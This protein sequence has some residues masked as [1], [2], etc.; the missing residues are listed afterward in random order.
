MAQGQN[1]RRRLIRIAAGFVLALV[2]TATAVTIWALEMPATQPYCKIGPPFA[3]PLSPTQAVFTAKALYVGRIDRTYAED[4]GHRKGL[5]AVARVKRRLWGLPWWSSQIVLLSNG[6]FEKGDEY[7][8]DGSRSSF[9]SSLMPIVDVG[10]CSRTARLEHAEIDLRVLHDGVPA[11]GARVIG[12]VIRQ[13][14][15]GAPEFA[16]GVGVAIGG[17]QGTT[18]VVSDERGIYDAQGL[19]PG[20]Y[21]LGVE[22]AAR[23]DSMPPQW[24]IEHDLRASEV[25]GETLYVK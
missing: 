14:L 1:R 17:S 25:W 22:P 15:G 3:K 18:V 5:W 7:F 23:L 9:L 11:S 20:H 13:P 16:Q 24:S 21:S 6:G 19:P 2:L 4:S 10:S 8:V 12:R